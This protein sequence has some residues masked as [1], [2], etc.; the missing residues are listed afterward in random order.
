[1]DVA[2]GLELGRP[3]IIRQ[4][5]A[6]SPPT[7]REQDSDVCSQVTPGSCPDT[8]CDGHFQKVLSVFPPSTGSN[9][10]KTQDKRFNTLSQ[11]RVFRAPLKCWKLL[12]TTWPLF[13]EHR[14][15]MSTASAAVPWAHCWTRRSRKQRLIDLFFKNFFPLV[16]VNSFWVILVHQIPWG[17][18]TPRRKHLPY[19]SGM[20]CFSAQRCGSLIRWEPL[21]EREL[22]HCIALSCPETEPDTGLQTHSAPRPQPRNT[23]PEHPGFVGSR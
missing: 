13:L 1:M 23:S 19:G 20:S 21:L 8:P 17:L 15:K 5:A 18:E 9:S 10:G 11:P 7:G 4:K 6:Q 2:E 16:S 14:G 12:G 3:T 22:N